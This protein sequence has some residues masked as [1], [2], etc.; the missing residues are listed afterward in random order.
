[1][2][3]VVALVLL[4]AGCADPVEH[5]RPDARIAILGEAMYGYAYCYRSLQHGDDCRPRSLA[6][7]ATAPPT[8]H[9]IVATRSLGRFGQEILKAFDMNTSRLSGI[10][11][12]NQRAFEI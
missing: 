6:S 11:R 1:L 9:S 2:K 12:S 7:C 10:L 3:R 4:L 8:S 5:A